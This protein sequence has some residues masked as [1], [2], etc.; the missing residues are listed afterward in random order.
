VEGTPVV[1]DREPRELA[2]WL[3]G[4]VA[5]GQA[6]LASRLGVPH[7]TFQRWLAENNPAVPTGEDLAR[8]QAVARAV[9]HLRHTFTGLGAL[10]W[11]DRPHAALGGAAPST[12]LERGEYAALVAL[13]ARS[14]STIAT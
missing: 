11:F 10:R 5:V 7:R 6:E 8:L 2:R 14:R 13:S 1:D 4:V 3:L 9:N 12:L